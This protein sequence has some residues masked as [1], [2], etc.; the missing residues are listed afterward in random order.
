[1]KANRRKLDFTAS[2]NEKTDRQTDMSNSRRCLTAVK[3]RET[4]LERNRTKQNTGEQNRT[5]TNRTEQN[6][7]EQNRTEHRRTRTGSLSI[8][9]E[10]E[11][12]W[13]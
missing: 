8:V 11:K 3:Q 6:T 10:T 4:E 12:F 13:E 7:D 5:Q 1:M 9:A 2:V